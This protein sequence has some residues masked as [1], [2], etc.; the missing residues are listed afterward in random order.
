MIENT[1][2]YNRAKFLIEEKQEME[3]IWQTLKFR[4]KNIQEL[5]KHN[6]LDELIS[7]DSLPTDDPLQSPFKKEQLVLTK[8]EIGNIFA[9]LQNSISDYMKEHLEI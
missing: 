9:S 3:S 8:S 4:L 2:K 7:D 6:V 5:E 1:A